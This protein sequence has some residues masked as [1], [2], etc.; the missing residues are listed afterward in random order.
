M[1]KPGQLGTFLQQHQIEFPSSFW[2]I[3]L[4]APFQRIGEEPTFAC[5]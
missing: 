4:Q 5:G 1:E 3:F 2:R